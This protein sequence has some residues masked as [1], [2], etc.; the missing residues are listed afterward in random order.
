M[1]N[2]NLP[3]ELLDHIVD[4]LHD[5]E[6]ALINC[7]LVSK[8]WIPRTRKHLFADVWFEAKEDLE[9]WKETFPDP[10]TSPGRY[11]NTLIID[12]PHVVTAADAEAGGWIRDFSHVVHLKL[13]GRPGPHHGYESEI[14]LVPLQG[15]SP[16]VKSLKIY[17]IALPISR[18]F[19]LILS[20]PLLEDLTAGNCSEVI[21]N[22]DDGSDGLP[23]I[24]QPLNP[25]VFT[26]SLRL[27]MTG[28]ASIG[29]R[30]LSL[31]GGIHFRK[32][33]STW[34]RGEDIPLV[35]ALVERCSHTLESLDI[36]CDPLGASIRRLRPYR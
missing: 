5:T 17:C 4:H 28:L 2:P 23:T 24:F 6:D 18:I 12:C 15:F 8:S 13:D 7:C 21:I 33:R 32:F 27:T 35:A 29:R 10:S 26:G 25:P 11:T 1:S 19:G 31:P 22:E 3:A 14:F 20:F 34:D 16:F 36:G 9:S 30:L